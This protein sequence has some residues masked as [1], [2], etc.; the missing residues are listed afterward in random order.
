MIFLS[1]CSLTGGG[2]DGGIFRSDD[3]G[4]TFASKDKAEN[5]RTISGVDIL[6]LAVN[7]QN[8]NEIYA[9]SKASGIFKS[10]DGG[11]LWKQLGVSRLT[12]AKVYSLAID[13]MNPNTLYA[14]AAIGKRGKIMKSTDTGETWKD[15]Y[16][17]PSDGSLVLSVALNPQKP[18]D[19]FAGTDQG[20]IIFSEDSGE[21]WRS[22]YWTEG[23]AAVSKIVFD[24]ANPDSAYFVL[25]EKGIIRTTDEG[26]NFEALSWKKDD[27]TF[28]FGSG[29]GGAVS[30][31]TDPM[32]GG[33]VY[34]GT[35]EGLLRS[36]D[37]GDNW[38]IVK[39]LSNP[40]E[41]NIR[42]IA[43]NPQNSDE[44]ICTVAQALYKS[45]DGGVNW[46]PVQFDTSRTLEVAEYNPQNPG[47][48]FVGLNKR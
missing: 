16:S 3:G 17:E 27:R 24:N 43:V 40:N 2:N 19:I 33:W 13:P 30:F 41:L 42:S 32:R 1:A 10:T 48:V 14:V 20:Q 31:E 25:F 29:L 12:P 6:S 22:A 45:V 18:S 4:K 26:K 38:E 34:A 47:Q 36:K 7:P 35:S 46:L 15:T 28:S 5:N 44:I 37:G 8:G 23:K 11:E 9:G 21:T 39:T